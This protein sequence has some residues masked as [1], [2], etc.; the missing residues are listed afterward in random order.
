MDENRVKIG[1]K[2]AS[3][4]CKMGQNGSKYVKVGQ[5]EV[6]MESKIGQNMGHNGSKRVK[7]GPQWPK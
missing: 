6:K 7:I 5:N 2:M 4:W 1:S 3:K